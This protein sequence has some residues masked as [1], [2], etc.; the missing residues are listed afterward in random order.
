MKE[1]ITLGGKTFLIFTKIHHPEKNPTLFH[2][3][4]GQEKICTMELQWK[5]SDVQSLWSKVSGDTGS[6]RNTSTEQL[7]NGRKRRR[8]GAKGI[9]GQARGGV[10]LPTQPSNG[11]KVPFPP[12]ESVLPAKS[13]SEIKPDL[14][15]WT[16]AVK[17]SLPSL[18]KPIILTQ[19]ASFKCHHPAPSSELHQKERKT[20][21]IHGAASSPYPFL[22][23]RSIP[24]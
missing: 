1:H 6:T 15:L 13:G 9:L 10:L 14:N 19:R 5:W 4:W 20:T 23:V 16:K 24:T 3:C 18:P 17:T 8:Q 7:S 12:S 11:W 2:L 22:L 21:Q